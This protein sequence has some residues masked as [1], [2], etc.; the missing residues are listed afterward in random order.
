MLTQFWLCS[1]IFF[2]LLSALAVGRL[3]WVFFLFGEFLD[4]NKFDLCFPCSLE[5]FPRL[6]L[7]CLCPYLFW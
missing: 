1:M 2:I 3:H 7:H 6:Q 5:R 4:K